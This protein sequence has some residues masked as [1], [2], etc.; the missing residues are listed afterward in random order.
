MTI[1]YCFCDPTSRTWCLILLL[2]WSPS[3]ALGDSPSDTAI[4]AINSIGKVGSGFD[5]AIPAAEELRRIPVDKI[6]LL[7][8]AMGD[9]N[10]VSENWLR[11]I[12]FDVVRRSDQV[13]LPFLEKYAM[14]PSHNPKGRGVAMELIRANSPDQARK[15]IGQCLHDTSLPLREM[16]VEQAMER[17]KLAADEDNASAIAQYR[18]VLVAARHPRQLS[19][20]IEALDGL[21]EKVS[22]AEA[23]AMITAW[24]SLAPFDNTDGV[25]FDRI[26]APEK[27]FVMT[28]T[29]DFGTEYEGKHGPIRWREISGSSDDGK[30]DLA[31]AYEKEKGAVAYLYTQFDSAEA[32]S[33]QARLG[34]INANKVWVNGELIMSNEVYH[35]GSMIDQYITDFDLKQGQNTILLKICQNEQTESWAQEWDFQ[36]RITDPLGK[37]LQS[38]K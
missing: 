1:R 27:T 8:D 29:V 25:G 34:C 20:I 9:T 12:I 18:E 4:S 10:P 33:A 36:F 14:D 7:F 26:Y 31:E 11:G 19:R 22:T 2:L 35:S 3:T 16:A 13:P 24:Q 5:A 6:G 32:T 23:F 37:G 15:L 21:G 28:G 30:V 17:A 38:A